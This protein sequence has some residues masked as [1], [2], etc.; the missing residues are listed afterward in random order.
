[1][2]L[3]GNV[4]LDQRPGDRHRAIFQRLA[5][6]FQRAAVELGQLVE[7]QH[8]VVRQADFARRGNRSAA[9]EAG[10]ADRMMRRAIRPRGQQRLARLGA[11]PWRCRCAWSRS[12]RPRP[13]R[14]GSWESAW[15]ASS[16]RSRADR[17]SSRLWPPAAAIVIGPLGHFLAADI[18]KVDVVGRIL[19]EPFVEPRAGSVRFPTR[20]QRSRPPRTSWPRE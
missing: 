7:K 8:A 10:V 13:G 11:S 4:V 14:A 20:R 2:K 18:G 3:A 6:H 16:C 1:M 17:A 15:P 5:E 9:D 12:I 19:A